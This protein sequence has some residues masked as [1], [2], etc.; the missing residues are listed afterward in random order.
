MQKTF[1]P[2]PFS[3]V[4]LFLCFLYS[5]YE[6]SVGFRAW[7]LNNR[8]RREISRYISS[9]IHGN[10]SPC[11]H[12]FLNWHMIISDPTS[13]PRYHIYR[14]YLKRR[15]LNPV[16]KRR[17][18]WYSI[19]RAFG[20]ASLFFRTANTKSWSLTPKCKL[21]QVAKRSGWLAR[22]T[23]IS[24]FVLSVTLFGQEIWFCMQNLSQNYWSAAFPFLPSFWFT[25]MSRL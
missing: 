7:S 24:G 25:H 3:E 9:I 2:L 5:F 16:R 1:K 20:F 14:Q 4:T 6:A 11:I 23:S 21:P 19:S 8:L 13:R 15:F 22:I 17:I 10:W 18:L 12:F